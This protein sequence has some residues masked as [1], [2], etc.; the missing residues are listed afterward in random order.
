MA[1]LNSPQ[2]R[3]PNQRI[4]DAD[5][6]VKPGT[7]VSNGITDPAVDQFLLASHITIQ[8]YCRPILYTVVAEETRDGKRIPIDQ[9]KTMT[10]FLAHLH[11]G[12]MGTVNSPHVLYH[13]AAISNRGQKNLKFDT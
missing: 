1:P 13:A 5:R 6:N 4:S 11:G 10:Y 3:H 7:C 9:L 12:V 2:Q 8:G